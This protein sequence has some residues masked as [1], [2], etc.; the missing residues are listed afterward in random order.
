MCIV[1][2]MASLNAWGLEKDEMILRHMTVRARN[3]HRHLDYYK[4]VHIYIP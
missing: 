4:D 1:L 2:E 3:G